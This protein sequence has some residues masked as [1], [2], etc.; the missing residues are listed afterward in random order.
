MLKSRFEHISPADYDDA[1]VL[2]RE[3]GDQLIER[4]ALVALK[5]KR[6]LDAGCGIGYCTQLLHKRY[7][8]AEVWAI[9]DS[10]MILTYAKQ[11]NI[12]Q[13]SWQCAALD[14]LPIEDQSID[15]VVGNLI[16]PWC[17]DIKK[18]LQEWH[19][20]LRPEGLLMFSTYGPD[21]LSELQGQPIQLPHF[22]DMHDLGDILIQTHFADP[23]LDV[24]YFTLTYREQQ[25]LQNEL[26]LTGFL[27]QAIVEPLKKNI[28]GV[29]PLT[30]EIIYGHAW[31]AL[32][33][34]NSS[35]KDGIVKFPLAHLRGR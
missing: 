30:Y 35:A 31:K 23:V 7:P 16:L 20:V 17:A 27:N 29:I 13:V 1:A 5:P 18:V 24:D 21:T 2:V 22:I 8:T 19:R 26:Q 4:L 10:S 3:A 14:K 9:D 12:P 11:L 33:N 32:A 15:L 25:R 28:D 34:K 6:I